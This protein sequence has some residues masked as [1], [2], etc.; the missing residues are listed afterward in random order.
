MKLKIRVDV[1]ELMHPRGRVLIFHVPP[2]PAGQPI[3]STG[4]Y[5]YYPMRAGESLIEMDNMTLKQILNEA[6]GR[7]KESLQFGFL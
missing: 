6:V 2:H 1:E 3:K 5:H 7:V 4:N